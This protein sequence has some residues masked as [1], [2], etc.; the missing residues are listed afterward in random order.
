ML[1]SEPKIF[2]GRESE[3]EHML[4]CFR[5][6][7]PRLAILGAGGMGKT[8]LARAVLHQAEI[9]ATYGQHR[10][11][12]PCDSVLTRVELVTLI[13]AHLALKPG[14]DLASRI[15]QHLTGCVPSLLVLDNMET[16]WDG[17]TQSRADIEDFLALL[18]DIPHL[19]LI[20]GHFLQS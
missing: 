14:K 17:T 1:P 11:F 7:T 12:V 20:V 19:A 13:G 6:E 3:L 9:A 10:F 4:A 15:V 5:L 16:I 18:T 8:T 2:H